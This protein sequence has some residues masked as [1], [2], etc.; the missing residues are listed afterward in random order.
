VCERE[1]EGRGLFFDGIFELKKE[2]GARSCSPRGFLTYPIR[3][4]FH[5]DDG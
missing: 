1:G 3:K 5:L 2:K 4:Y